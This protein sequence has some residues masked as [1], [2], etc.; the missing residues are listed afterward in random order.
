MLNRKP[1]LVSNRKKLCSAEHVFLHD[2][3]EQRL[4]ST[5]ITLNG[6]LNSNY[7]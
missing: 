1:N 3:N 7:N 5:M 6:V 4:Q 2:E